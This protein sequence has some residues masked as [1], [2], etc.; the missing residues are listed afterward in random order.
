MRREASQPSSG[1]TEVLVPQNQPGSWEARVLEAGR[2]WLSFL[3]AEVP[4]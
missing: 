3:L 4:L 1:P 2:A